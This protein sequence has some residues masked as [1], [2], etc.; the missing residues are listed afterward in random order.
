MP[1]PPKDIPTKDGYIKDVKT[2]RDALRNIE[3]DDTEE[4]D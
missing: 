3:D 4:D 2:I 1:E